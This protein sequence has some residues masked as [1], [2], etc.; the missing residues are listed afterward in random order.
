[1]SRAAQFRGGLRTGFTLIEILVAVTII[2]TIVSMVYGSYFAT[3]K[4][5]DVYKAKMTL[6][7]QTQRVLR[8]MARQIRCSYIGKTQEHSDSAGAISRGE[9]KITEKPI[10][11]FNCEP[12]A[13]GGEILHLVT[14]NGLFCQEGLA[15]GL[16]DVTYKFDKNSGTL[17]LSQI[18]F[19]GTPGRFI[20]KRNWRPLLRNVECIELD[21]FDGQQWLPK[22]DFKQK[23]KLPYAVRIGITSKDKNYRQCHY[24]T[25][26]H[27]GCSG[28]R[29]R[30]T[31]SETLKSVSK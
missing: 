31:L 6:S 7:G 10:I 23:K 18:R 21:F 17:S 2:V 3:A 8:Q 28:S 12:D 11:Y 13:R 27:V 29:G 4:S 16:F 15:D 25:I 5:T 14:T 22:W 26:A 30:E 19:V 20:E 24:G 1:M 9:R